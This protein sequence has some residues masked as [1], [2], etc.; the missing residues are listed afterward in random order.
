M[1]KSDV[2]MTRNQLQILLT[3]ETNILVKI[4]MKVLKCHLIK[5]QQCNS[6]DSLRN[7]G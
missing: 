4:K 6:R 1:S 7:Q 2:S 3:I 5:K